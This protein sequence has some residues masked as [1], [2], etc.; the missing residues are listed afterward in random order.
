MKKAANPGLC[1]SLSLLLPQGF[2]S[3][4]RNKTINS[5]SL[6]DLLLNINVFSALGKQDTAII[7]QSIIRIAPRL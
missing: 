4:L 6:S 5:L 2:E 7:L 1:L 3:V